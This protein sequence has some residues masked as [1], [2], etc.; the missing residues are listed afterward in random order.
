MSTPTPQPSSV[1]PVPNQPPA[2]NPQSDRLP[3]ILHIVQLMLENRSF[4]HMLGFPLSRQVR[5]ERAAI[6]GTA[7]HGVEQRH[8]RKA[9]H[10]LPDRPHDRGRLLHAGRRPRRGI[11]QYQLPALRQRQP[12]EPAGRH[13]RRIRHQ[14]RRRHHVRPAIRAH[15]ARGHDRH[16]TS[17]GSSRRR[18]CQSCPGWRR[19][20]RSA[21]TGTAR[22]PTET[23]PNR[24][25]ACAGTSQG[26]MNDAHLLV[27]GAEHLRPDDGAQPELEDLRL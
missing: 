19:G 16:R 22:V 23:F 9:G 10:G 15:R 5:S 2:S 1:P 8:R 7:R 3:Q 13:E 25:F 17:W 20:L 4:D 6:R 11:R 12:A 24:A 14:L 18:P 26:H 27:H 21:T